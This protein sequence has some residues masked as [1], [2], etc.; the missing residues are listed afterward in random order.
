MPSQR[1]R[2]RELRE[3]ERERERERGCVDFLSFALLC[4]DLPFVSL[5]RC[6]S[7]RTQVVRR[8]WDRVRLFHE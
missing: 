7:A 6:S 5:A 8:R 3:R 4:F 1:E 2:E